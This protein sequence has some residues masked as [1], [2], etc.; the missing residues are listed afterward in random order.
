MRAYC[1]LW[2]RLHA[3]G[4]TCAGGQP[5]LTLPRSLP[6]SRRR[7][8]A[9]EIAALPG[10]SNIGW[11]RVSAK[12]LKQALGTWASKWVYVFTKYLQDK[13][14]RGA[15]SAHDALRLGCRRRRRT[16]PAGMAQQLTASQARGAAPSQAGPP[17]RLHTCRAGA[18]HRV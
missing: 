1:A 9:A 4:T 12:P 6:L 5:H 3:C 8:I 18:G 15:P 16:P 17:R 11:L 2:L 13:V 14:S 7:S 10:T